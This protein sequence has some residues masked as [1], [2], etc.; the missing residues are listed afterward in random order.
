[1]KLLAINASHRGD[2]GY[3]HFLIEQLFAGARATGA[4]CETLTLARLK[5]NRCLSCL[6]CQR[7]GDRLLH[8]VYEDKDDAA[9][10]FGKM[11]AADVVI[12]ATPVYLMTMS[13]LLKTL[14]D[15]F[16]ST[17]DCADMKLSESGM[18]HH[19]INP[20]LSSKPF[21]LLACC[22]NFE[23]IML[24]SVR[25]YFRIYARMMDAPQVG[26]L[27]RNATPLLGD[28]P[29]EHSSPRVQAVCAAYRQA[30]RELVTTGRIDHGTQRR[31][32]QELVD[33]PFFRVIKRLRPFKRRIIRESRAFLGVE[34]EP[35]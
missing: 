30:G 28:P 32:N 31:A 35:T 10:I 6:K 7:G 24:R 29:A 22:G 8:C 14:L 26:E 27:L 12:Y 18:I 11:V 9:Q 20:A 33:V 15:R 16:Y 19:H 23:D 4:D 21:V 25:D 2:R 34:D 13:G 3:T 1:M 5:I 17:M